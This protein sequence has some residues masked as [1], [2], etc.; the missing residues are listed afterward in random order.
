MSIPDVAIDNERQELAKEYAR[1]RRRLMLVELLIGGLYT[2]SWLVFGWSSE[3]KEISVSITDNEWILVAIFGMVFGGIYYLIMVPLSYFSGFVL[4]HRFGLSTQTLLGWV[5]DQIKGLGVGLILGFILLEI[6]YALLRVA[7]D[8]WWILAALAMLLFNVILAN[9]AP[10]ILF[11]IFYKFVPLGDDHAELVERL[12]ELS[13]EADTY[14]KGVFK[15]DM[16]RRTKAANAG[17]TGLGNTRRIILGDTLIEEFTMD[18]IETILAHELGHHINKDIPLGILIESLITLIGLYAASLVLSW[19]TQSLGFNGPSDVA[20]MPLFVLVMGVYGLITMPL[21][22]AYSRWRERL[23]DAYAIE[24]TRNGTAYASALTRLA[25]QNLADANPEPWVEFLLY[26]H[27][28]LGRRIA[29]AETASE[30][31]N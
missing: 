24:V 10:V 9:L 26:S 7:P 22:N 30:T 13:K 5:V 6:I 12:M 27:P 25:N 8:T 20:A 18:E 4:P 11:P 29:Y 3:L 31:I 19:G 23:A 17:L 21:G 14:V 15:F 28:S 2:L 16:S 1:I